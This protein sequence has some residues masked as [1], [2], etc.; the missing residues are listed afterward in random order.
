MHRKN[1]R[2]EH[3]FVARLH[4]TVCVCVCVRQ[5][6]NNSLVG[7][8]QVRPSFSCPTISAR[9]ILSYIRDRVTLRTFYSPD[10]VSLTLWWIFYLKLLL[11]KTDDLLQLVYLFWTVIFL[12]GLNSDCTAGLQSKSKQMLQNALIKDCMPLPAFAEKWLRCRLRRRWTRI[13]HTETTFTRK[14]IW[15]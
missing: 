9:P 13:P 4:G 5:L 12:V 14:S 15:R 10:E 1:D 3:I 8:F 7:I 2:L 11:L 6:W